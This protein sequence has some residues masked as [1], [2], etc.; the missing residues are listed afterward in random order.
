MHTSASEW[1]C[2]EKGCLHLQGLQIGT[3]EL[4]EMG[5]KLCQGL[6]ALKRNSLLYSKLIIPTPAPGELSDNRLDHKP[7]R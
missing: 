3:Q 5:S 4:E 1:K 6:L 2:N 7:N